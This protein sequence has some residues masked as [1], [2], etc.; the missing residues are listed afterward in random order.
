[1][2]W[3]LLA[4]GTMLVVEC[5]LRTSL[6]PSAKNLR[7]LLEKIMVIL[8]SSAIS[9]HWKEKVLPVYAGRLFVLSIK[10]FMLVLI[11][12]APMI[13]IAMLAQWRGVPL[14]SL[15]SSWIGILAS[16]GIAVAYIVIRNRVIPG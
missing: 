12:L 15:L 10:L 3:L 6:I 11:S 7:A 4:I 8:K 14:V 5:F 16:S 9:D 1:M 2:K 13:V